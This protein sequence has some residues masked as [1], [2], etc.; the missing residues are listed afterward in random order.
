MLSAIVPNPVNPQT[1]AGYKT[2]NTADLS[3]LQQW[4]PFT[5]LPIHTA[6]AYQFQVFI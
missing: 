3:L 4:L 1:S 6:C 2:I 5:E